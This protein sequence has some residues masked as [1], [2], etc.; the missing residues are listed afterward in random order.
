MSITLDRVKTFIWNTIKQIKDVQDPYKYKQPLQQITCRIRNIDK[1]PYQ[2]EIVLT[3]LIKYDYCTRIYLNIINFIHFGSSRGYWVRLCQ[4]SDSRYNRW[5]KQFLT[6]GS[7]GERCSMFVR[8][9]FRYCIPTS[10]WSVDCIALKESKKLLYSIFFN[11]NYISYTDR[12]L[13]LNLVVNYQ[14]LVLLIIR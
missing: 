4:G 7:K 11:K 1:K 2:R 10:S 6:K 13:S 5:T 8:T 14:Q 12:T 3:L 9:C